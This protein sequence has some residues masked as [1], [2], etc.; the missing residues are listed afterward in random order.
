VPATLIAVMACWFGVAWQHFAYFNDDLILFGLAGRWGLT[1]HFLKYNLYE[2]FAA[3]D[4]LL[5]WIELKISPLN[6]FVGMIIA[7][8][9][10][11]V[12]LVS[13]DWALIEVGASPLRRAATLAIIGTCIPVLTVT[14]WWGQAVD[15]PVGC[16]CVLLIVATHLRAVRLKSVRWHAVAACLSLGG[17]FV[18]ERTLFTPGFLVVLDA[19]LIA[20]STPWRAIPRRLWDLRY[21]YLPLFVISIAGV[22][23]I[24]RFYYVPYPSGGIAPTLRLIVAAFARWF[25]PTMFGFWR[26][27]GVSTPVA[28]VVAAASAV[29]AGVMVAL[30]RR[31]VW[32]LVLFGVVF[33]T[34]YGFLG[35]ERLG[36]FS[37]IDEGA[38]V[39][40]MVWVLPLAAVAAALIVVPRPRLK[41]RRRGRRWLAVGVMLATVGIFADGLASLAAVGLLAQRQAAN[42]YF[43]T[44]R[45]KA[46][47]LSSSAVSVM[48]LSASSTVA[49]AFI[50]PFGRLE[51]L[52]P[53][54]VPGIHVGALDASASPVVIDAA[55]DPQPAVLAT[56]A[57]L[58]GPGIDEYPITSQGGTL[59][60]S[61]G[62]VCFNA[63]SSQ[64]FVR[65][66]APSPIQ[67]STLMV[68]LTYSSPADTSI[69]F[70]TVTSNSYRINADLSPLEIGSHTA[71]FALDGGQLTSLDVGDLQAGMPLCIQSL[72][73][74]HPLVLGSDG[75]CRTVDETGDLGATTA[76]PSPVA[77]ADGKS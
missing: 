20:Q 7:G 66:G 76:C 69:Q 64:G 65:L 71:V 47:Q 56:D 28:A 17:V 38:D 6:D 12:M 42:E 67:G 36:I 22:V 44:L 10:L 2:H 70:T 63:D 58:L 75:T 8:A 27:Y 19:A 73:I 14:T 77:H 68:E 30:S 59:S 41:L 3:A 11:L 25:V 18:S 33:C 72:T 23:L 32:P 9:I 16:A 61:P 37:E 48:P 26:M 1:L 62:N 74:V 39:Q 35:I 5:Y 57:S 49:A 24:A 40:Y 46:P 55:G 34:F 43:T 50:W 60:A 31:N 29:I 13:L 4:H 15:L 51:N 21:S 53:L 45:S 54:I 52:L